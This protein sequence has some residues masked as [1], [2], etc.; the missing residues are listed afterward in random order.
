VRDIAALRRTPARKR[1]QFTEV[2]VALAV[3]GQDYHPRKW[4]A[5]RRAQQNL[6]AD[7]EVEP[8]FSRLEMR[9]YNA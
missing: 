4:R 3:L 1:D 6:A 2:A 9:P 8:A 7:D 5:S